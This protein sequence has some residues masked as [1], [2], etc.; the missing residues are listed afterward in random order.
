MRSPRL[1]RFKI[2]TSFLIA[3]LGAIMCVRLAQNV[4]VSPTTLIDFIAPALFVVAGTW[5][6]LILYKA[7]KG[8][9]A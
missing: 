1:L 9:R 6:G 8:A 5:R 3:C 4:P 2:G 7:L